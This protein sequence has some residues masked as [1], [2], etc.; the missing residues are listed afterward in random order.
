VGADMVG[1]RYFND[2]Q[3]SPKAFAGVVYKF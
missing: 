2:N 3:Y 1:S